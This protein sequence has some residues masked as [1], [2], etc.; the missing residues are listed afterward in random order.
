MSTEERKHKMIQRIP[1]RYFEVAGTVFG[2]FACLSIASQVWAEWST[3]KPS[4]LSPV[5]TIGFLV[6]F[7]FWTVY[8]VRFRRAAMWIT[9]GV[10]MFTQALLLIVISIK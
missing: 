6:V 8:G 2:L 3:D 5:F 4:T 7:G 9:N 1:D 10:A